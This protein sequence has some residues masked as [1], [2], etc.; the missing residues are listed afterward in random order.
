MTST[1]CCRRPGSRRRRRAADVHAGAAASGGPPQPARPCASAALWAAGASVPVALH[2]AL[3]P[4]RPSHYALR[5]A[6]CMTR[7]Y[8]T[9]QLRIL[10]SK[11]IWLRVQ[12]LASLLALL[13]LVAD[14]LPMG[15]QTAAA[16]AGG[17]SEAARLWLPLALDALVRGAS[18]TPCAWSIAGRNPADALQ[19]NL[20]VCASALTIQARCPSDLVLPGSLQYHGVSAGLAGAALAASLLGRTLQRT[21]GLALTAGGTPLLAAAF[22]LVSGGN[23]AQG[24][25]AA[26]A[27]QADAWEPKVQVFWLDTHLLCRQ[28]DGLELCTAWQQ[29]WQRA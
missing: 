21:V 3:H 13:A 4:S 22:A 6:V 27:V 12:A 16:T 26:P 19:T 1:V 17:T 9:R 24:S 5:L 29:M 8:A 25:A 20:L 7:P 28:L 18:C 11:A 15:W 10:V 2:L 14:G 23:E